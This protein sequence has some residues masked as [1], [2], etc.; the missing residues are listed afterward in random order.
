MLSNFLETGN[1]SKILTLLIAILALGDFCWALT[2]VIYELSTLFVGNLS[3]CA[4]DACVFAR[5][6]VQF[7]GMSTALASFAIS[8]CLYA[9]IRLLKWW[10][11]QSFA[12]FAI[13]TYLFS[14]AMV[15]LSLSSISTLTVQRT[16]FGWCFPDERARTYF[17]FAPISASFLAVVIFIALSLFHFIRMS[18]SIQRHATVNAQ[19]AQQ[20]DVEPLLPSSPRQI[21]AFVPASPDTSFSG[22][23]SFGGSFS[24]GPMSFGGS[25]L[26]AI[27]A[28]KVKMERQRRLAIISMVSYV[29]CFLV[30]WSAD[31]GEFIYGLADGKPV[32]WLQ[33]ATQITVNASGFLN[34]IVY[35]TMKKTVRSTLFS[36]RGFFLF[37]FGPLS[38]LVCLVRL[39]FRSLCDRFSS[40]HHHHSHHSHGRIKGTNQTYAEHRVANESPL[41]ERQQ[42]TPSSSVLPHIKAGEENRGRKY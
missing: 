42:R 28:K 8:T 12:L 14:L 13:L 22:G 32:Y 26:A 1:K 33:L 3:L 30:V 11:K 5:G 16:S 39:I 19:I 4:Y 24:R 23:G 20:T 18:N 29:I 36:W 6:S 34:F 38:V 37:I 15:I 17:W 10:T 41:D 9:E 40:T 7:W 21:S 2:N 25:D 35:G 27:Q 31:I